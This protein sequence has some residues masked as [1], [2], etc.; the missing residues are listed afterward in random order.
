M[1]PIGTQ[2]ELERR[3]YLAVAKISEGHSVAEVS[4]ILNVRPFSV[5]RWLTAVKEGG[6]FALRSHPV[7]GRPHK[8]TYT[9]EKIVLRW[10]RNNP[11]EYG[12]PTEL[13]TTRRLSQLIQDSFDVKFNWHYLSTWLRERNFTPQFPIRTPKER[14]T[15]EITK[16]INYEWPQ[17]K[18]KA[19]DLRA[20]IAFIDESGLLMAPLIRRTWSERGHSPIIIQKGSGNRGREKVSIAATIWLS[21]RRDHLG[22]HYQTLVNGYF[23][24][25]ESANYLKQLMHTLKGNVIILWDGGSMHKGS[26]IQEVKDLYHERLII[27]KLPSYA[28]MLNPVEALWS[29]LK[30]GQLSNFS[31]YDVWQMNDVA[32]G[33]MEMIKHDQHRLDSIFSASDLKRPRTLLT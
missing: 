23:N 15:E 8:L 20:Y 18:K 7:S 4:D 9:Q 5:H 29:W 21:P 19:A 17:I 13:W 3:R 14:N 6:H 10:I 27:D 2:K 1:R 24:S 16:W 22:T 32:I 30:Y 28:P 25:Y 11:L 31:P 33:I 26:F 12:F